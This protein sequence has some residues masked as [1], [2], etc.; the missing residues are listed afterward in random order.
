MRFERPIEKFQC[1][2]LLE[3]SYLFYIQ[4]YEGSLSPQG[5]LNILFSN[6][7]ASMQPPSCIRSLQI[8]MGNQKMVWASR[9]N[10]K[11]MLE[12]ILEALVEKIE[13]KYAFP[14]WKTLNFDREKEN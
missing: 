6:E 8:V 5:V 1:P 10:G 12:V 4:G 11:M 7:E 3:T 13:Q 2:N 14:N 9:D